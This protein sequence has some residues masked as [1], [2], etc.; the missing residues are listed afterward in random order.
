VGSGIYVA[1]AGAVAQSH[2]LDVT[3]NNLAN[4]S[5]TGFHGSRVVFREALA[6][7]GS[8]DFVLVDGQTAAPST[9]NGPIAD[10]DN[11]LDIALEGDGFLAV[12][13]PRGVRYTRAGAL[14]IAAD[15]RLITADG[16]PV[17]GVG[18]APLVIPAG[19]D[20]VFIDEDGAV[21]TERGPVGQLELVRFAGANHSREGATLLAARGKPEAGPPPQVL[22]H[23]LEG[24][25]VNVV[26]GVVELVQVSRT[27]ESL[28]SVIKGFQSIESR[29]ARDLG[30]PK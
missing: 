7:V 20:E 28:M 16:M 12:E 11:P 4:A 8:P 30:G 6:R 27:Y 29:A 19:S 13:S 3:A 24:S 21:A 10:T 17:R 15:G 26:R 9:A 1:A 18:G 25:N 23:T 14:E 2:A 5:T 22:Q